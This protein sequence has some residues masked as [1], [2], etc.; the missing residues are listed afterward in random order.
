MRVNCVGA[1]VVDSGRILL[2]RRG[3]PPGEGLWSVPGGRVEPGESDVEAVTREVLEETGLNIVPGR[4]AGTVDRPG[5]GG[6]VYE[7]RDYLAALPDGSDGTLSAG[8]DAAD[9]RWFTPDELVRLPL[10]TGL[11][12][13]L[14]EWAVIGRR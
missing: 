11:L 8:S 5:P 7:I 6:V 3:H 2:I 4:L 9:A 1:I 14:V 12:D 10:T 13:A